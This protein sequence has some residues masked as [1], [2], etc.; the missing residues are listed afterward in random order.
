MR[1]FAE[2]PKAT[3][4]AISPKAT[5]RTRSHFGHSHEVNS[6][7]H[8]QRTIGNQAVQRLLRSDVEELNAE[9]SSTNSPHF[10]HHFSRIHLEPPTVGGT[11]TKLAI[12]KPGDEYE[13][14][15]NLAAEQ[16][17]RTTKPSPQGQVQEK[18]EQ[19]LRS[20]PLVDR[21][22]SSNVGTSEAPPIVHEVLRSPGRP[23]DTP[24][25][26]FMESGFGHEFSSVRVHDDAKAAESAQA[27]GALAYT[28]GHNVVFGPGAYAP[29]TRSGRLLLSH[30]LSHV[31]QQRSMSKYSPLVIQ[32]A[33]IT[34]R[35]GETITA[36]P[37]Q[38]RRTFSRIRESVQ[39]YSDNS[40]DYF[41]NQY[42]S[43][44]TSFRLWYN[45]QPQA[46][47]S[48][49]NS[50]VN[51]V[52]N[53]AWAWGS[54]IVG[55]VAAPVGSIIM[56]IAQEAAWSIQNSRNEFADSLI[57]SANNLQASMQR[58]L[59]GRVPQVI[60]RRSPALWEEIERRA[61]FGEEWQSLLHQRA[62]LPQRGINYQTR[63]LSSLIFEYRE[64]ELSQHSASYRGI[65][66]M[67]DP[68]LSHMRGRARTE[69]FIE[70]GLPIPRDLSQ[71]AHPGEKVER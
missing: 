46:D 5:V 50:V 52:M 67:A 11:H 66:S 45:R 33:P 57:R 47:A 42:L 32:R 19:L 71:Y 59:S 63:L 53:T 54:P 36:D 10:G 64:W 15:A 37:V 34:F 22:V 24:T 29:K 21:R 4:Q 68:Y 28:V 17:M 56:L 31:I 26:A 60:E 9:L 69:A 62:G 25:R 1:T 51:I 55:A 44:M 41:S 58:R 7:L 6:V 49:F 18:E 35:G 20:K 12:N 2:K 43:A 27:I 16:V 39:H 3:Q 23:L 38:A 61:Y 70:S 48:F 13:Q 14:E 30:E 65:Y 8:L 40:L